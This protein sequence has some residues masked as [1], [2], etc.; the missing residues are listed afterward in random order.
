M[1]SFCPRFLT[2]LLYPVLMFSSQTSVSA[3]EHWNR[4]RG[5]EM[6]GVVAD[7]PRLP[8]SWS[9]TDHVAWVKNIPGLGWSSPIV[10]GD[11]VFVTTVI[12]EGEEEKPKEGL[13]FG[14]ER[15]AP[16]TLHRWVVLCLD[17]ATG[18]IVWEK[19]AHESI[20]N[21]PR[22]LK[23][24]YA[25]ETPVTDGER[26]YAYFGN[27]GL[28]VSDLD[29]ALLWEKKWDPVNI[30][31]GWGTASSPTLHQDA[32]YILN[33]N[34]DQ[35]FLEAL[36]KK[37]GTLI[38]RVERDEKSNW[39]TPYIWKN[40]LRTELVTAGAGAVRSYD[41]DGK[42]LWSFRG[43]SNI[44][45]PTPFSDD[46]LLY[47]CS[48][49]VGDQL[50]PLYAIRPGAKGDISL[51]VKETRNE[52]IVWYHQQ[53][54]PYMPSPVVYGEYL[55]VLLDRGLLSCYNAKTGEAIYANERIGRGLSFTA[56][57]WAYNGKIFCLDEKGVT[58]VIQ[59]GKEFRVVGQNDL[60]DMCMATP[61]VANDGLILRTASK[62]YKIQQKS[63]N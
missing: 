28:F 53:G 45:A 27:T 36:D 26:I 50:R 20:P 57:P 35:S 41:L 24:T 33:D 39:T 54:G 18:E 63:N 38:W 7:N 55:Y 51:Q 11:R 4:F 29:G 34:D 31:N 9:A 47:V 59:A 21:G 3:Q 62:V 42:L 5:P 49:Y 56:S 48:G 16:D 52:Y 30:R 61:A 25:S 40:S 8:D 58:H 22:H 43:M 60:Q 14:G 32:L 12:K 13:Y 1:R 17:A 46:D 10:W 37:T 23:N 15:P 6:S 2:G 19:I 44:A